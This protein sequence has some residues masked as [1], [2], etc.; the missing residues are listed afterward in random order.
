[1]RDILLILALVGAFGLVGNIQFAAELE[2]EAEE[3]LARVAR[4]SQN[5]MTLER[6]AALLAGC[7]NSGA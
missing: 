2:Q 4:A 1:M 7:L 6:Y 3:K 5:T